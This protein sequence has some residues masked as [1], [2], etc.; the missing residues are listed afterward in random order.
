MR[1]SYQSGDRVL[2]YSN[3]SDR[4]RAE[5]G[6][7][8]ILARPAVVVEDATPHGSRWDGFAPVPGGRPGQ[9]GAYVDDGP[10]GPAVYHVR[11]DDGLTANVDVHRLMIPQEVAD[12]IHRRAAAA[13]ARAAFAQSEAAQHSAEAKRLH[14]AAKD[15]SKTSSAEAPEHA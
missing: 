5:H 6:E 8:G 4:S 12:A 14:Q 15:V 13:E 11:F 1:E 10:Q 3:P 7:P 9:Y 2:V